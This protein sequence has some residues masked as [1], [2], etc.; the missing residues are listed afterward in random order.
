VGGGRPKSKIMGGGNTPEWG[1][2]V[3]EQSLT[4]LE[5]KK[6]IYRDSVNSPRG[7]SGKVRF[8]K[9]GVPNNIKRQLTRKREGLTG[10]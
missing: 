10:G 9:G 4:K 6:D 5:R 3:N 7:P 1:G 2:G 8:A